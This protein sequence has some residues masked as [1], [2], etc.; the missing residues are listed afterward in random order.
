MCLFL[1]NAKAIGN[2]KNKRRWCH[3]DIHTGKSGI[4]Q[5]H[6]NKLQLIS[7]VNQFLIHAY[8]LSL[9]S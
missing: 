4:D 9:I 5:K 8:E 2:L 6:A 7:F 1:I 3:I